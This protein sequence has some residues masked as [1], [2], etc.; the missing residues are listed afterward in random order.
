MLLLLRRKWRIKCR[1][2]IYMPLYFFEFGG[3][4]WTR[5]FYTDGE[6]VT[7]G[8]SITEYMEHLGPI[9][10]MRQEPYEDDLAHGYYW[11]IISQ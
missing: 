8:E 7:Y 4:S 5:M 6:A 2:S 11:R 3:E 10:I 9:C 1:N